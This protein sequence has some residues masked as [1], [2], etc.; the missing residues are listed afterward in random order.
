MTDKNTKAFYWQTNS[1]LDKLI[2]RLAVI[3]NIPNSQL[4][5]IALCVYNSIVLE[6]LRGRE[7]ASVSLNGNGPLGPWLKKQYIKEE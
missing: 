7:W 5:N 1:E 4:I 2:T 6:Q 3:H